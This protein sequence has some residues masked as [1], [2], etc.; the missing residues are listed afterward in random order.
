MFWAGE[1]GVH[2]QVFETHGIRVLLSGDGLEFRMRIPR[3]NK[4]KHFV[5]P[6]E[7]SADGNV[8]TL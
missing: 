8:N 3:D 4:S 6:Q 5:E 2:V 7:T 1:R